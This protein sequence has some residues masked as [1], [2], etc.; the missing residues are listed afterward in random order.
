MAGRERV[1][2]NDGWHWEQSPESPWGAITCLIPLQISAGTNP[3]TDTLRQN[4]IRLPFLPPC[5]KS[6]CLSFSSSSHGQASDP[7]RPQ[8]RQLQRRA[9]PG[10]KMG[11]WAQLWLWRQEKGQVLGNSW[12]QPFPV[13][14]GW[15]SLASKVADTCS[16]PYLRQYYANKSKESQK[17]SPWPQA[18]QSDL[19][20]ALLL[21]TGDNITTDL[22]NAHFLLPPSW[23]D[24]YLIEGNLPERA[25][26]M[27]I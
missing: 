9:Q 15:A 7:L 11:F 3:K 16:A 10:S 2:E 8:L 12:I 25:G 22:R 24:T 17:H 14:Q 23:R 6:G 21:A 5:S 26:V 27:H 20:T 1:I 13:A 18:P 4:L 19:S